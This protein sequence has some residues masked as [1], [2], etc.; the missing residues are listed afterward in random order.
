MSYFHTQEKIHCDSWIKF[1]CLRCIHGPDLCAIW[2][3]HMDIDVLKSFIPETKN[4]PG[5]CKMFYKRHWRTQR[6]RH[7]RYITL[8]YISYIFSRMNKRNR[9]GIE[10]RD[11]YT[12]AFDMINDNP[13]EH[14]ATQS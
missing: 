9:R 2:Q 13:E 11:R 4:G 3:C 7:Y 1:Q 14:N 10:M 6:M 12:S 8:K 5:I